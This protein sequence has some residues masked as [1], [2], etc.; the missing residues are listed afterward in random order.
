M[1]KRY[2]RSSSG[3]C[4]AHVDENS[5]MIY[6]PHVHQA[7]KPSNAYPVARRWPVIKYPASTKFVSFNNSVLYF[8]LLLL[9][10]MHTLLCAPTTRFDPHLMREQITHTTGEKKITF[11]A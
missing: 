6:C 3:R 10:F 1:G 11:P 7:Q 9:L 8:F 4:R 5:K 2:T